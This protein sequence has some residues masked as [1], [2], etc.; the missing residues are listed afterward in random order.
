MAD[1]IEHTADDLPANLPSLDTIVQHCAAAGYGQNGV[2]FEVDG[3]PRFWIKYGRDLSLGEALTQNQ[4]AQIVNADSASAVRVPEVYLV[5]FRKSRR[6]IV[7]QYVA[8]D[9]VASRNPRP[10]KCSK[11]DLAA[12]VG[13]VKQLITLRVPADTQPGYIGGGPIGHDFF[14]EWKSTDEY[15]TVRHLEAQINRVS[16]YATFTLTH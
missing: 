15:P 7:M 5:F 11:R 2:C 14:N 4:V 13:A 12:V 1:E 6:Y 8:G 9:T 16:S 10:G 3:V